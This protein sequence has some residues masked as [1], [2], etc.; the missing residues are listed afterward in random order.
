MAGQSIAWR[1]ADPLGGVGGQRG[2]PF[3]GEPG[4]AT[5]AASSGDLA[6]ELPVEI[7]PVPAT[8]TLLAGDGQH[9]PAAH[10]LPGP[11]RAQVVSRGG[12][13]MAGVVV[14]FGAADGAGRLDRDSDT[15]NADGIVQAAWT[16]GFR[17]GRQ[18]LALGVEENAAIATVVVADADP[19]PDNTTITALADAPAG[20]V[21]EA[22][23]EAVGV[24]VVDSA[25]APLADVPVAWETAG[26]A[27]AGDAP[28]TDSLGEAR[29][30]WTLGPRSGQQQ[31]FVQ[32]GASRAVPRY[33]LRASAEPGP[34]ATL[35]PVRSASLRGSAGEALAPAVEFQVRDQGGNPVPGVAVALRPSSGSVSLKA[36]VTDSAG[37]VAVVWTLGTSAGGQ[38]LG[39][40]AQGVEHAVEISAQARPGRAA[41]VSLEGVPASAPAGRPLAQPVTAL[42]ADV[43]GNVVPGALVVFSSRSGK[44]TPGRVRTDSSGRAVARWALGPAAGEQQLEAIMQSGGPRAT[45]KV[46]AVAAAKRKH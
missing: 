8:I 11:V 35:A 24:R 16:L 28:R 40:S 3:G 14:R 29:A 20:R 43:Y 44:L 7:Y 30:R 1:S 27:I 19:S 37:R 42:V 34:A 25:G 4:H 45:A 39:A 5:L 2:P 36:P 9:A 23:R 22:L 12:R 46:R 13:P 15:S 32:V 26:G 17:P 6:A 38:R 31:A 33:V 21:R 41:K 18:R 10:R